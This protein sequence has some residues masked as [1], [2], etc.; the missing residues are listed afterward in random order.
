[1]FVWTVITRVRPMA[2]SACFAR[3]LL[4][5]GRDFAHAPQMSE[6]DF[7]TRYGFQHRFLSFFPFPFA[8][9]SEGLV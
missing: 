5:R 7:E 9:F 6:R 8:L 3:W 1:M 4:A 2:T